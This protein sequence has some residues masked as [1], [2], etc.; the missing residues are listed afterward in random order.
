VTYY[1]LMK[2]HRNKF[3]IME[4][5]NDLLC[6]GSKDY[7]ESLSTVKDFNSTKIMTRICSVPSKDGDITMNRIYFDMLKIILED[8]KLYNHIFDIFNGG[9]GIFQEIEEERYNEKEYFQEWDK[10]M[11]EMKQEKKVINIDEDE[12]VKV[13]DQFF[14]DREDVMTYFQ[15]NMLCEAFT[16][17]NMLNLSDGDKKLEEKIQQLY[18][19]IEDVLTKEECS[20]AEK[21]HMSI[22]KQE[23]NYRANKI[24][25]DRDPVSANYFLAGVIQQETGV[26]DQPAAEDNDKHMDLEYEDDEGD[27]D[28]QDKD[29]KD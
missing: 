10:D 22:L 1:E 24:L 23:T 20:L 27:V 21:L 5:L 25:E 7:T 16:N 17:V 15:T 9:K 26:G 28:N 6:K 13:T 8:I 3:K 18:G 11:R 14:R 29:K 2:M 19:D 12:D 4:S